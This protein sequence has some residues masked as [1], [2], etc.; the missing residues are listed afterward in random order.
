MSSRMRKE[1]RLPPLQSP[2]PVISGNPKPHKIQ[3]IGA[4]FIPANCNTDLI[5]VVQ[6]NSD[7]AFATSQQLS[8]GDGI[9]GGISIGA[10]WR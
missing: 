10:M 8:L 4:G 3:G 7:T 2:Q 5:D 9:L 6:I 1:R